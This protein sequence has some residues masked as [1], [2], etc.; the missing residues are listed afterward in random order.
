MYCILYRYRAGF[1]FLDISCGILK[2]KEHKVNSLTYHWEVTTHIVVVVIAGI[3]TTTNQT[4]ISKFNNRKTNE[5]IHEPKYIFSEEDFFSF[6]ISNYK[7][8][9]VIR[10][11]YPATHAFSSFWCAISF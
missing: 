2:G 7:L 11:T 10:T 6:G 4:N 5:E 8:A 9:I 3:L 1:Q